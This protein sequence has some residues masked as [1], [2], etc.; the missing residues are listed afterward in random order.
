MQSRVAILG[1]IGLFVALFGSI[2]AHAAALYDNLAA[3]SNSADPAASGLSGF[4]PLYHSFS[5]GSAISLGGFSLLIDAT[6]PLDGGTFNISVN[7]NVNDSP[8]SPSPDS[9]IFTSGAFSDSILSTSLSPVSF[10]FA[11]LSLAANTR[12]WIGLTST[13]S[14]NWA[15]STDISGPGVAAEFLDN[16]NGVKDNLNG[17][18]Q[19]QVPTEIAAT[20]LPATLPLFATSIFAMGLFGWRRKRKNAAAI[21][22]A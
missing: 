21:A 7:V 6:D 15:W 14:V 16:Q 22:A 20:P 12:Y 19:M 10:S 9:A 3:A 17:P 1:A 18:Y 2:Q 8:T 11:P 13:G 4:G 5:T